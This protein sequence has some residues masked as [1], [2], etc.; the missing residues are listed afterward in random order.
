MAFDISRG[1]DSTTQVHKFG[2]AV[3][4]PINN[5]ISDMLL[6][7]ALHTAGGGEWASHSLAP[8]TG[9]IGVI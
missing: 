3:V 5:V 2:L 9:G 7:A 4:F 1:G 8:F 6:S